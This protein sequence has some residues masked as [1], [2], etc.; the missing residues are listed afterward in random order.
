MVLMDNQLD[1][2]WKREGGTQSP[3]LQTAVDTEKF[4]KLQE[5][6]RYSIHV[7]GTKIVKLLLRYKNC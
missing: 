3:P 5:S 4:R 2:I 6:E 7:S 1:K